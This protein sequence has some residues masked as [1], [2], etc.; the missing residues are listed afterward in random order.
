MNQNENNQL[1]EILSIEEINR[2][3]N[4]ANR[5]ED[6]IEEWRLWSERWFERT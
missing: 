3:V 1:S 6:E 5:H 4:D 2:R